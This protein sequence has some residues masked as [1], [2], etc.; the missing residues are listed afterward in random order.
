MNYIRFSYWVLI[1]VLLGLLMPFRVTGFYRR[2][3]TG[4]HSLTLDYITIK[5]SRGQVIA[6]GRLILPLWLTQQYHEIILI[7]VK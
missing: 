5:H 6:S 1:Q 4:V 2:V 3:A 7:T